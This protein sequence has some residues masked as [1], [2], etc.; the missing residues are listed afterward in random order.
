MLTLKEQLTEDMKN[1][2]RSGEQLKRD[3]VRFLMSAIKN[4]EIDN[5][6]QNDDGVVKIVAREVKKMKDALTDF[7]KAGRQDIVEEENKKIAILE[8]YLPKQLTPEELEATV[9]EVLAEVGNSDF[10]KA[11]KAVMAKVQGKADG[12]QVSATVKKFLTA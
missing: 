4:F 5:G 11:M 12:G 1:A 6:P 7:I 8:A 9:K 2:M 10:G 3:T